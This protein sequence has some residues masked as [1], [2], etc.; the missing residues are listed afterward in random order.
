MRD[1]LVAETIAGEG[2]EALKRQFDVAVEPQLWKSQEQLQAKIADFRALIV[3]NQTR[4]DRELIGAAKN[5]LVIGR[6]GV[7]LDNVD[8]AAATEAGVVVVFTP[9]QNAISVAE[10]TLGLMLALSR[11][12]PAADS[13]TKSGKWERQVFT[14]TELFGK[15]LGVVGLG[16]IGFLVAMRAKAFGMKIL[17]HDAWI[18]RDSILLAECGATL[19]S[20][21]QLLEQ[22]DVVSV[23]VPKTA[24]TQNLFNAERLN[25]MKRGALLINTSRGEVIDET[26]LVAALRDKRLGGAALDVRATEPPVAGELEKLPNVVLTPHVAAFTV[27]GQ[28]RVV[29][30]VCRDVAAVLGGS[31]PTHFVNFPTPRKTAR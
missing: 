10:L 1:V 25:R 14:G 23:H 27:E 9:E 5:L 24:E 30:S 8:V 19:V 17:A 28:K 2:I 22:S 11:S 18:S 12:I 31:K 20:L 13:S 26:A 21:E 16:R 4:V 15:T 7:G 29:D 3:R 6:A